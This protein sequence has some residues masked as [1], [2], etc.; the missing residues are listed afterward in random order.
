MS[1]SAA[2]A[3]A[4]TSLWLQAPADPGGYAHRLYA[5]LRRLDASD[6]EAIVVE[7][8]PDGAEWAGVRDRLARAAR[9]D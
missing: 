8:V 2:P 4:G 7:S 1:F 6:C 5:N 3:N 9:P